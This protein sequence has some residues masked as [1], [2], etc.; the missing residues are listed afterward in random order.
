MSGDQGDVWNWAQVDLS[1]ITPCDD[2]TFELV[3]TYGGSFTGDIAIDNIAVDEFVTVTGCTDPLALNYDPSANTDDGSCTYCTGTMVT[4][5]MF[6]SFGDG[7][8]GATFTATG[9]TTGTVF[10]PY[11]LASGSTGTQMICMD[12]DCYEISVGGGTWDS[13]I[14]WDITDAAGAVLVSGAAPYY[15]QGALGLNV[16]CPVYGCTDS[17][18]LNFDTLATADDG[19]CSYLC[20]PYV[21]SASVDNGPSCT[22][23]FDASATATVAGSFGNDFWLWDNGS[24]SSTVT[25]L[26]AGTYSVTITDSVNGCVSVATV[27]IDPTPSIAISGTTF[28]ATPGNT[29][30]GVDLTVSGG[31]PCYNGASGSAAGVGNT[32]T[33]WA[34]NLFDVV[35]SSDLQITSIDMPTMNGIGTLDVYYRLGSGEGYELDPSAWT[36]AGSAQVLA[37]LVGDL[38]NVPVA[39][40]MNAGDTV[41]L[42]AVGVGVNVVFGAGVNPSYTTVVSSDANIS[43][44]G[45]VASGGAPGAGTTD[46]LI[47]SYDFGGNV[48]YSLS[49]YTYAWSSGD[50]TEDV[51]GLGLGPIS[52]TVTDCN[53]CTESWTGFILTNYVYGCMDTLASNYDAAANTPDSSCLYDGCTDPVATN[54]DATANN[55]DGSCVYPCSYYGYD[56]DLTVTL[57]PDWFTSEISWYLLDQNLDTVL[58]S[59]TYANGGA[60][61]VQSVCVMNGCYFVHGYDTFGDGWGGGTLDVVDNAGNVVASLSLS[62]STFDSQLFSVGGANCTAGC[63]D[64]TAANF[65]PNV[66]VDDGSCADT[67]VGCTDPTAAN[68]T[69]FSNV[70][71][72]SCVYCNDTYATITVGGGAWQGEVGWTILDAAGN[73][74]L[75]GGAPY[76]ADICL[77]DDC[78]TVDMTDSFGDGWNGNV[79]EVTANGVVIASG[80]LTTGSTGTFQFSTGGVVCAVYGCTDSTAVNYDAAANTDDGSCQY[81]CTAAPYLQDFNLTTGTFINNGWVLNTGATGSI[82]TGPS[83]DV[84]G[85]GSYVYFETSGASGTPVT[86]TSECLDISTLTSPCLSWYYHMWGA[87]IGSLDVVVNGDT[88]WTLAGDQGDQWTQAQVDLSAYVGSNVTIEFVAN[89]GGSFTGDIAIDHVSVDECVVLPVFGCIDST[90]TNYDPAADTD[91]GSCI[92]PC[93]DSQVQIW[94]YDSWGDGWNGNTWTVS[95]DQGNVLGSGT[96]AA[97]VFGVD[98]ICLPDGCYEITVGG[99]SFPGEVSFDFGSLVGAGVGTYDVYIGNGSCPVFGCTDSTAV[100]YDPLA[101]TDDGSCSY[102]C[103]AAPYCENFDAGIGTWTNN[104]WT[105]DA[106]GTTSSSTG[107]SDDITGGGN[108]MYF[109]TSSPV[110]AGDLVTLTSECLDISAL[111][112]PTLAFNYH[113][114][115]ASMGTLE[116]FVNGTSVWSLSGDQGNQWNFAQV[117]LSAFVGSSVV[118]DFVGT[119]ADNGAGIAFWGDMAIDEVCVQDFLV[120]DGCTDPL[121]LNYDPLANN[122]D[123]SCNYCADTY[124]TI[125]CDGGAWQGE[126]SWTLTNS[127]GTVVLTGGAP[128]TGSACLADDCYTLDMTDSFGDGW[129]GNVWTAT[130][131]SGNVVGTGGLVS[132]AAGSFDFTVGSGVCPVYG[133]TDSTA[134]NYDPAA[135]TDDGSCDYLGCT[136]PTATNYDPTATIDDGSCTF[137]CTLDE[138]TL[139]LYDSYGDGWNGNSLTVDGVTYTL[140]G[141]NDNGSTASFTNICID[142]SVCNTATYNPT[143]TWQSENSWDITDASGNVIASGGANSGDFGSCQVFGCTDPAAD[144]YDP[145]ANTDDGSCTY[146]ILGC[147]DPA[148]CNYDATAT[149]DDGSCATSLLVTTTVCTSATE[150][151]MT[152][153]W[154]N[155]DPN[156]GPIAVDNGN[157][158]WT[159]TFCPA[160]TADMEYLL[161][162]DG[163]QE[164]LIN[165][166]HP[167][168]DGDGYG[169]LWDC[170]PITDYWSYANRLWVV[171]SGDVANTYGTC[172]SCGDVYGCTDST[173]TNYD[174]NANVGDASCTYCVY[175]CTDATQFN[176]DAN[177]TCDDG[178]CIPYTYGCTDPAAANYNSSV[179]TDDGSCIYFGCTDPAADNYDATATV[180]DGSCTYT[181]SGCTDPAADNYDATATVDDGSCTYPS[182]NTSLISDCDDFVPGPNATWTHVLVATTLADGAAS[183]AAQ[184]FTMNVTSL[185]A[186]GANYRVVKT[187]ANGNW[188][189]GN[190]Q[191]LTLGTNT[192]T[193]AA[194]S[195]DRSVKFQFSSEMWNLMH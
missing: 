118:I 183:Q 79:L 93:F 176:Y 24:T 6:D 119:A 103:T 168:L 151:R 153:P 58:S 47:S 182:G 100:N 179:N 73:I 152:G 195:F 85:G 21:A 70:D 96:L 97:G 154:W 136:N 150:V 125:T 55:D 33:Q 2:I 37:N 162:V 23:A 170:S 122:D 32:T 114:Y 16:I 88:V 186:G 50:S 172:G 149:V 3:A 61:D 36:L 98:S 4:L 27:T 1:S 166:P 56:D 128:F 78:Y 31:T 134:A 137:A 126:V 25:G 185:P 169:D 41:S 68:Y 35:A 160:P 52:V 38:T 164:N 28:D 139:T 15:D 19:S 109:E 123:G 163:V 69:P 177:A 62:A 157:G 156:G 104:G 135:D 8:N 190:A 146:T 90:A 17:T 121:A 131:A 133:C 187:V 178:S 95:D 72:G 82:G 74:V 54:Y 77:A 26:G 22:G 117:D 144:N 165:A 101:D 91:D 51:S 57:T 34:G 46:P 65:D 189:N 87:T 12:D 45:G 142:L 53:G 106:L 44:L 181:V 20:D 188:F 148:A 71:D 60:I 127:A 13:E 108:Y 159:F 92:Y 145:A 42:Y 18:A 173:A 102:A 89:Y 39:I 161:V 192:V 86:L 113:M 143:G 49:S 59:P 11:T 171:G 111:T 64:S 76:S 30:G 81:S 105:L 48:N 167:D 147:T 10:G 175:G 7:W 180:D 191:A 132:G 184:T 9:T 29:N 115:G 99:G 124:V 67:I 80:T 140:D 83:D 120:I 141:I 112:T 110:V 155:W 174:P 138:V 116:V 94:M 43:M 158:T 66:T 194:V 84:S 130:D 40:S 5:N 107:P 14:T 193:V 63:T 129:N 75:Q